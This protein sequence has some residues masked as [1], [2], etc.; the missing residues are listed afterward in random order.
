MEI[1][2]F[3]TAGDFRNASN[4]FK[5]FLYFQQYTNCK[6][7]C[8]HNKETSYMS[9]LFILYFYDRK[10]RIPRFVSYHQIHVLKKTIV[11][12]FHLPKMIFENS[13]KIRM[14]EPFWYLCRL[15]LHR[16]NS[17]QN[18]KWNPLPF[19]YTSYKAKIAEKYC[20]DTSKW[21]LDFSKLV[22]AV[23]RWS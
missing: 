16:D 15:K 12:S 19:W 17:V 13:E 11:H 1:Q 20:N 22:P 8:T 6:L 2:Y 5:I 21:Y 18:I 10:Y 3:L 23:Y 9:F 7:S 14:T 4:N